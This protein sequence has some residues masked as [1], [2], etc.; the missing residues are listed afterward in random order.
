MKHRTQVRLL[1]I[2]FPKLAPRLVKK[3]D[4]ILD[5]A[6]PWM[7]TYPKVEFP[8]LSTRRGHRVYRHDLI[9]A[10]M[11]A[12]IEGGGEGLIAAYLHLSADA[13]RDLLVKQL[14]VGGADVVELIFNKY[15]EK[16]KKQEKSKSQ[17]YN[18]YC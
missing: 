16:R 11:I 18:H 15:F 17:T 13:F 3:I 9:T 10:I 6:E 4:K 2:L 12:I 7:L 1:R 8:G 5:T 14:G